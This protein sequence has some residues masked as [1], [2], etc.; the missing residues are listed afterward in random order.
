MRPEYSS[1]I[2]YGLI[3]SVVAFAVAA[4]IG[5]ATSL[6]PNLIISLATGTFA[7]LVYLL[8]R[9]LANK[10]RKKHED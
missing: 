6:L 5:M 10:T 3:V 1:A 8:N 9:L 2:R 4:A 7:G